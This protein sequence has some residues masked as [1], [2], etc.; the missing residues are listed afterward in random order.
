MSKEGF[1]TSSEK[2]LIATGKQEWTDLEVGGKFLLRFLPPK[3]LSYK[4]SAN[5]LALLEGMVKILL[6]YTT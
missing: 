5:K 6:E 2:E 1:W 3:E 4:L